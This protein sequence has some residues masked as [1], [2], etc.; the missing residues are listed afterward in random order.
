MTRLLTAK[1]AAG[2][3]NI[4]PATL[5]EWRSKGGP[6]PFVRLSPRLI[7]YRVSDVVR[8]ANATSTGRRANKGGKV[9]A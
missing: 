5:A 4:S 9:A 7:R 3:L 1:E 6:L 2:V 8:V